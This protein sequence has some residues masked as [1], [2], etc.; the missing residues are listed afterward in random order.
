[1]DIADYI[2]KKYQCGERAYFTIYD[3]AKELL[4]QKQ[5]ADRVFET[6]AGI[7][8]PYGREIRFARFVEIIEGAVNRPELLEEAF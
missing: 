4:I 1:M 3:L 6:V 7:K 5:T 8:R 2:K